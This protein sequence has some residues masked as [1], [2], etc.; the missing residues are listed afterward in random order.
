MSLNGC[1]STEISVPSSS[2]RVQNQAG[3]FEQTSQKCV[4]ALEFEEM[5]MVSVF[6]F[7]E[8]LPSTGVGPVD[9]FVI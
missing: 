4:A 9:I 6:E 8:D 3:I 7:P 1:N 2:S 5:S